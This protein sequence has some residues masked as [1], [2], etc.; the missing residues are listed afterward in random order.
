[1]LYVYK[2]SGNPWEYSMNRQHAVNDVFIIPGGI[3]F[4]GEY[5]RIRTLLG[6]CVSVMFWHPGLRMGGMCH[7]MLPSRNMQTQTLDGRY[8]DEAMALLMQDID[9]LGAPRE[10]YQ[11]RVFGGGD[12]FGNQAMPGKFINI[13]PINMIGLKNI[14]AARSLIKTHG[15][16]ITSEH[17]GG[18]RHRFVEFEVWSG[19]VKMKCV[20][21]G[22]HMKALSPSCSSEDNEISISSDVQS[23]GSR[24]N[25]CGLD[26][27]NTEYPGMVI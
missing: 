22:G 23:M 26:E 7:F 3:F 5:T 25:L 12:M 4:G 19:E 24:D 27:L 10:E 21:V 6:S 15:F 16:Q 13:G 1:M 14:L 17:L 2:R 11:V 18:N 9:A 20:P 8:A